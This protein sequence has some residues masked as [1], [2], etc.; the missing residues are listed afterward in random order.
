MPKRNDIK[1]MEQFAI[2]KTDEL[3]LRHAENVHNGKVRIEHARQEI[4]DALAPRGIVR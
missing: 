2:R 4:L 3:P 1:S